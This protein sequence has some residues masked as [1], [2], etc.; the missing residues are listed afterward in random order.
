[1]SEF[2]F[3]GGTTGPT[4]EDLS[5]LG[6]GQN[7]VNFEMAAEYNQLLQYLTDLKT[8][9]LAGK[10]HGLQ[11][12]GA[13]AL[14][15]PPSGGG[16]WGARASRLV[17]REDGMA[18][19][20]VLSKPPEARTLRYF[21][22]KMDSTSDPSIAANNAALA[23]ANEWAFDLISNQHRPACL[24]V[25]PGNL[26][27]AETFL[28]QGTQGGAPS[29][30]SEFEGEPAPNLPQSTLAW[31]G[32]PNAEMLY[33]EQCN[34]MLIRGLQLDARSI[35]GRALR[36]AA[37]AFGVVPTVLRAS[38][39]I[40]I[41]SCR[42]QAVKIQTDGNACV[43]IGTRP[44]DTPSG[45]DTWQA[46]DVVFQN[47]YFVG[48]N[49]GASG[50][51]FAAMKAGGVK[52]LAPGNCKNFEFHRC[53]WNY[54][55]N[56]IDAP[57]LSGYVLVT[58]FGAA[59]VR[60]MFNQGGGQLVALGGDVECGHVDQSRLLLQGQYSTTH[61][62]GVEFQANMGASNPKA[63]EAAG[64]LSLRH[65][66]MGHQPIGGDGTYQPFKVTHSQLAGYEDGGGMLVVEGCTFN[67]CG[68]KA[69]RYPPIEDASGNDLTPASQYARNAALRL[70]CRGNFGTDSDFGHGST[71]TW[72][73]D[74]QGT[75][76]R[77]PNLMPYQNAHTAGGAAAGPNYEGNVVEG[78]YSQT[79]DFNDVKTAAGGSTA[80]MQLVQALGTQG[81]RVTDV[82]AQ[83]VTP[84]AGRAL[85]LKVSHVDDG[86]TSLLQEVDLTQAAD[87]W[88]GV[89]DSERGDILQ[90]GNPSYN[91]K[92]LHWAEADTNAIY[93]R[94]TG[95][96]ALSGL[97]AGKL[98]VYL[99]AQYFKQGN[100]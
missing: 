28:L 2:V 98:T 42:F 52:M 73:Y 20:D 33:L 75:P 1:M 6:L 39:A 72:L 88:L 66:T 47:C 89:V 83:I 34:E 68:S 62:E 79:F 15:S 37:N 8:A 26:A 90:P 77:L 25:P 59:D 91:S 41:K 11:N 9:L 64:L 29:L 22:V 3:A 36:I 32:D 58:G 14:P 60:C 87:T 92:G 100:Y 67:A 46:S 55:D 5:G 17:F 95:D 4:K 40:R 24:L 12:L 44:E 7:L 53:D 54:C 38:N 81:F 65:V 30:V 96:G 57:T 18:S 78:C 45:T 35:A 69:H 19:E 94:F 86:S 99:V 31:Y 13:T 97:S 84:F 27:F 56:A 63:F 10:W 61:I 82:F 85:T 76:L 50:F 23:D 21:G 16:L 49:P 48:E 74:I 43:A 93:L 80:S 70:Y 71:P 51:D